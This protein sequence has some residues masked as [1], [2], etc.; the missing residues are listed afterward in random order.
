[1][2]ESASIDILELTADR[3]AVGNAAPADAAVCGPLAGKRRGADRTQL[4][5]REHPAAAATHNRLQGG[6]QRAGQSVRSRSA[7]LQ[8]MKRHALRRFG[9]DARQ[10]TQRVDE[11]CE[12]RRVFHTL[13]AAAAKSPALCRRVKALRPLR[14]S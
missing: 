14:A 13:S 3:Y 8:E 7:F 11:L 6:L 4:L 2:G 1:M 10:G 9:S 12:V 5:L